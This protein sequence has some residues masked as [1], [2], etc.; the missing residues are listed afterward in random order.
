[1]K[2]D[3]ILPTQTMFHPDRCL[4]A[5]RE[6]WSVVARPPSCRFFQ[7]PEAWEE[8]G[9]SARR[10][11]SRT[12][13]YRKAQRSIST[14]RRTVPGGGR[15]PIHERARPRRV[16]P[17][18]YRVRQP[19]WGRCQSLPAA[20]LRGGKPSLLA[21]QIKSPKRMILLYFIGKSSVKANFLP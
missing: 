18:I 17:G 7:K 10:G 2:E 12:L 1:M 15:H 6:S 21:L 3:S 14:R 8:D 4:T 20:S 16:N 13:R 11:L 9:R 5:Q 19:R